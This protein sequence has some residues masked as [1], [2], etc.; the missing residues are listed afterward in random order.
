MIKVSIAGATS[1][2]GRELINILL[3]H[4]KVDLVHL[5]GRREGSPE[6]SR[7]FPSLTGR[8][9]LRLGGLEPEDVPEKPDLAFFTLPHGVSSQ[10]VPRYLKAG[11]K[12]ID[13]SGAY[14]LE[15]LEDYKKFY[16]THGD[17]ENISR[18]VYGIPELFR[19]QIRG[20]ALVAN[21]GCYPTSVLLALAPLLSAGKIEPDSVIIDAKSGISGRGNTPSH[22]S[23]FCECNENVRAYAVGGHRHVPEVERG[24]S[25]VCGTPAKVLFV[26]H[27]IPMERG[28]LST[29]Y[30]NLT[31]DLDTESLREKMANY[32]CGERFIRVME[33][34]EQP[35]TGNVLQTNYCDIAVVS[36]G[37]SRAVI[38]SAIDNLGRGAASQAVQ[39]MN[40]AMGLEES[41]GLI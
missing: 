22:G 7:I 39:N 6:I 9:E 14:R 1:Y 11:I 20:A 30:V 36:A 18:A 2:T 4:P 23:L 5:G 40:I 41:M 3:R 19:D 17:P 35:A 13:F 38:T 10:Y 12:C 15:D 34:G 32:Y 24:M 33:T 26:P 28:I 31:E 37:A 29:I 8:C 21:P 16:G 25:M 27:L